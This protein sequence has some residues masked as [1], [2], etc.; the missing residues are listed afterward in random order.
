MPE[1]VI[2]YS[3]VVVQRDVVGAIVLSLPRPYWPREAVSAGLVVLA[4]RSATFV[5]C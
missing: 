4:F 5:V 2:F 3:H 1:M